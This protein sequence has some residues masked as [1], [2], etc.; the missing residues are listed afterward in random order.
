MQSK[1]QDWWQCKCWVSIMISSNHDFPSHPLCIRYSPFWGK[2]FKGKTLS[3]TQENTVMPFYISVDAWHVQQGMFLILIRHLLLNSLAIGDSGSFDDNERQ[4]QLS[5]HKTPLIANYRY[6]LCFSH[7]PFLPLLC[8]LPI[9]YWMNW[10]LCIRS[11]RTNY[12]RPRRLRKK[13]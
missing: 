6:N 8:L 3:Y 11:Y 12:P 2:Y 7:M 1:H 13:L 10:G 9:I 4:V 5:A